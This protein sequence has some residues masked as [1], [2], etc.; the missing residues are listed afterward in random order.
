MTCQYKESVESLPC[1]NQEGIENFYQIS[2]LLI[3]LIYILETSDV[4]SENFIL[5]ADFPFPLYIFL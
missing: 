2:G 3:Y 4:Q 1:Q 5:S